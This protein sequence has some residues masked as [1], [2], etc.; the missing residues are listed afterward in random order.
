MWSSALKLL[1]HQPMAAE[2]SKAAS[3]ALS[4]APF[5]AGLVFAGTLGSV[6]AGVSFSSQI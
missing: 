5:S 6:S 1:H 4:S 3:W 2:R